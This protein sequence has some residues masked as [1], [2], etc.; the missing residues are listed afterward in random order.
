[1]VNSSIDMAKIILASEKK[2]IPET[3]RSII[4]NLGTVDGFD[5]TIATSLS[6]FSKMRNLLAHEYLDIRFAQIEKIIKEETIV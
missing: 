3:Y 6:S 1:M 5:Q 4:Y 2:Q